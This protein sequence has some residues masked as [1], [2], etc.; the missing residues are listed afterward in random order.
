[1]QNDWKLLFSATGRVALSLTQVGKAAD[2]DLG[3]GINIPGVSFWTSCLS[4][5]LLKWRQ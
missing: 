4:C 2:T 1:M 3:L 5:L